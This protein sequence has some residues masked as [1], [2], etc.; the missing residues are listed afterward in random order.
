VKPSEN[1]VIRIGAWRVDP[2]LDE[3]SKDGQSAKLE[4][5]MMRLLVC[6]AEHAG[7][8]VSVD[9]LLDEVWKGVIVT[10]DSVYHAVAALRRLLGDDTKDPS[11][12]ANVVRRGYRLVAPV[13]PWVDA[14]AAPGRDSPPVLR[15]DV[16]AAPAVGTAAPGAIATRSPARWSGLVVSLALTLALAYFAADRL[17]LSKHHATGETERATGASVVSDKSIAVLPFADMSEKKDQEYFSDGLSEELL[18]L[19]SKVPEL[20][21]AARTSAFA[22]TQQSRI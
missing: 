3:I 13:G 6:L 12:I 4:P 8:V 1:S 17:W 16:P 7:Q 15:E 22:F 14:P 2:A 10:P 21:V 9:Q 18:N 11:Y 20:H 19:L 5:K